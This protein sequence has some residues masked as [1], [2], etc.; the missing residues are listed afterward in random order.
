MRAVNLIP[1]DQRRGAGGLAGRT[2][3]IVYVVVGGLLV[4]VAL[5]LVY[6]FAVHSVADRKGQLAAVTQQAGQVQIQAT[7][8]HSYVTFA[9]LRDA[10]VK[11]IASVA[12]QRFNWPTAMQQLAL[13]LPRDVTVS[14]WNGIAVN[15]GSLAA[16][17][18]VA[19]GPTFTIAGCAS[20]QGEV[21]TVLTDLAQVPGVVNVSLVNAAKAADKV[22]NR[23]SAPLGASA[24]ESGSCQM[25]NFNLNLTY[26]PTY[27]VPNA[28]FSNTQ[29]VGATNHSNLA[30]HAAS[31]KVTG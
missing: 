1:A 14:S 27:T 2:G 17:T 13:A 31:T 24:N 18:Q 4:I 9:S 30:A 23:R 12:E 20:S 22:P 5:G 10:K 6:A 11:E 3:G 19:T 15:G 29:T 21:A 16:T 25:V 28:K 26:T 8:L 7:A